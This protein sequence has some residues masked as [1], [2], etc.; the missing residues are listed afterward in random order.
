MYCIDTLHLFLMFTLLLQYGRY[1]NWRD[2]GDRKRSVCFYVP[3]FM[4]FS[5]FFFFF[6]S[7]FLFLFLD[8]WYLIYNPVSSLKWTGRLELWAVG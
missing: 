7:L 8:T 4:G 1:S 2:P 3:L 5:L 6:F